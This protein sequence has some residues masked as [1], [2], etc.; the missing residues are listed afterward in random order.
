MTSTRPAVEELVLVNV[1]QHIWDD[2]ESHMTSTNVD[3]IEMRNTAVASGDGDVFELDV[4]VVF[5]Y[6]GC[7]RRC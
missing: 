4:H 3:L 5:G 1:P 7:K 6:S 2:E